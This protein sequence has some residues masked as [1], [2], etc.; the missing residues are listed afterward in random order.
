MKNFQ[1]LV[2]DPVTPYLEND[3]SDVTCE[4][5]GKRG[6]DAGG[7]I[8]GHD[9]SSPMCST[10][11]LHVICPY[12]AHKATKEVRITEIKEEL[13]QPFFLDESRV[14]YLDEVDTLLDK[15]MSS[16]EFPCSSHLLLS[17]LEEVSLELKSLD[18]KLPKILLRRLCNTNNLTPNYK[19][20]DIPSED[21]EISVSNDR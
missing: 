3:Y 4:E 13:G 1:K 12:V 18:K 6:V 9:K 17:K 2:F 14:F 7:H 11:S 20:H 10:C 16:T 19:L 5:F 21:Y 15:V 8:I